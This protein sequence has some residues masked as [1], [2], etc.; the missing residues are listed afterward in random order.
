M[1]ATIANTEVTSS[2]SSVLATWEETLFMTHYYDYYYY[3]YESP[4]SS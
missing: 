2:V 4:N 1:V 3:Y